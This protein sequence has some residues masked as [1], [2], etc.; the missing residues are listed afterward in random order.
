M[1]RAA[2]V[3]A[4]RDGAAFVTDFLNHRLRKWCPVRCLKA[5]T[6]PGQAGGLSRGWRR[7]RAGPQVEPR[8][9]QMC[10]PD[11][12]PPFFP[13][14]VNAPHQVVVS[15]VQGLADRPH[16]PICV[17]PPYRGHEQDYG[18]GMFTRDQFEELAELLGTPEGQLHPEHQRHAGN[19]ADLRR[20][21][22]GGGEDALLG[23]N[24]EG[25]TGPCNRAANHFTRSGR[26]VK[27]ANGQFELKN[28]KF[29]TQAVWLRHHILKNGL[30]SSLETKIR[31]NDRYDVESTSKIVVL[32]VRG[33]VWAG[34]PTSSGK[35][36][37]R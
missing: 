27:E 6:F 33:A 37:L 10:S 17:D 3:A 32:E 11:R 26:W 8:P 2:G 7:P 14:A 25:G 22:H 35:C 9:A 19:Q 4:W 36:R 18:K 24:E 5:P 13:A 28:W 31:T 23:G 1:G 16:T 12:Q 29:A 21:P 20:I 34:L 30:K 15:P